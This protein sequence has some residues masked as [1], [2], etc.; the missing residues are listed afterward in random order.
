MAYEF[1]ATAALEIADKLSM[2]PVVSR[3]DVT[4]PN[5]TEFVRLVY[6]ALESFLPED[7]REARSETMEACAVRLRRTNAWKGR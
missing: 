3:N 1:V 2:S 6:L 4:S 7:A 5:D